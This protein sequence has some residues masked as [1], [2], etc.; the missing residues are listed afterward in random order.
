MAKPRYVAAAE[1]ALRSWLHASAF[2]GAVQARV[3]PPATSGARSASNV[4]A[5]LLEAVSP[6][7]PSPKPTA[8]TPRPAARTAVLRCGGG[9][10]DDGGSGGSIAASGADVAAA[11]GRGSRPMVILTFCAVPFSAL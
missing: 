8:A 3:P 5:L 2:A 4:L 6:P 11:R 1:D 10:S 7:I 9:G